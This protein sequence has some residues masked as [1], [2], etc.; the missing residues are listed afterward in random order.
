STAIGT[1]ENPTERFAALR[2]FKDKGYIRVGCYAPTTEATDRDLDD[3][4]S[5]FLVFKASNDVS[6]TTIDEA[7]AIRPK[8]G[9]NA[10]P[11]DNLGVSDNRKWITAVLV[12]RGY[13]C[14]GFS[15]ERP[16]V[17]KTQ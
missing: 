5:M 11:I 10:G 2:P 8:F 13:D 1:D 7:L 9:L 14:N 4:T 17:A 16:A 3:A 6:K 15:V 12:D